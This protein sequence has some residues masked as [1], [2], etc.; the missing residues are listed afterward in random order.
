[1]KKISH[2]QCKRAV[3]GYSSYGFTTFGQ[4]FVLGKSKG[5][6]WLIIQGLLR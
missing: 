1:M 6:I 3:L 5:V 4:R 2:G